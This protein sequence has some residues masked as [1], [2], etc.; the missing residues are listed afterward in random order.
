MDELFRGG[1]QDIMNSRGSSRANL[2]N[3]P[4]VPRKLES[5]PITN[6][7]EYIEMEIIKSLVASYF[8]VVT[9]N[10][11]DMVPKAIMCLLVNYTK[12]NIQSELVR[13]LYR[14]DSFSDLLKENGDVATRRKQASEMQVLLRRAME[15]VNE[16]R[17]YTC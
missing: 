5:G 3:L 7:H 16:V 2:L 9:K 15:I 12:V 8:G 17:D 13:T 1:D 14:E 4:V 10:F 6:R 11:C